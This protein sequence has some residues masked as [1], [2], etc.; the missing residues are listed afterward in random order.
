MEMD[1]KFSSIF[2]NF[3]FILLCCSGTNAIIG[4]RNNN[5]IFLAKR[6]IYGNNSLSLLVSGVIQGSI[7]ENDLMIMFLWNC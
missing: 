5:L 7:E 3:Q 6:P 2:V 4:S 1:N